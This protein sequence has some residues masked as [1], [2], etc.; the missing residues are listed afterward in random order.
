M[1]QPPPV[2]FYE[3]FVVVCG[4]RWVDR[5]AQCRQESAFRPSAVSWAGAQG[6]MQFMP[7][8]WTW[9]QEMGWINKGAHPF[10]TTASI[11]AGH[12]FMGWLERRWRAR[13][14]VWT[15]RGVYEASL[16]SYNAGEGSILRADWLANQVGIPG[17]SRWR[18]T[19]PQVTGRHARETLGYGP[20]IARHKDRIRDMI[21][22]HEK[23]DP[24]TTP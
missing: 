12:A 14:A 15:Q 18:A 13:R 8:T 20:A 10:E 7:R 5:A 2:P 16:A 24:A 22:G 4:D 9:A 17:E 23:K 1:V 19:L 6:L 3:T 21:A 11:K